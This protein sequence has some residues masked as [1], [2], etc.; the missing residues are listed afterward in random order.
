MP[1]TI[2]SLWQSWSLPVPATLALVLAAWYYLRGW[3]HLRK[4]LPTAIPPWRAAA[5][6]FGTLLVWI[7]IGSPLAALDE[8]LLSVHMLQHLLLMTAGPPLILLGSPVLPLLHGLPKLFI[9]GVWGPFFRL[10][11]VRRLERIL[12]NP[13]L[14]WL[15]APVALL[16]WHVPA[17]YELGLRSEWWHAIEHGSFLT[18]GLLFWWPVIP[19]WPGVSRPRW[20]L[21]LYLFLA[22]L[23]C[24][25]L[26][27]FLAFCD[28]VVYPSYLVTPRRV[29]ITALQDQQCAGAL[30]WVCVTFACL[31]PAVAITTRL[32]S[33]PGT[34]ERK[35]VR[36]PSC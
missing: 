13:V 30:M 4:I 16:G 24:D 2:Q 32:L 3:L 1:D 33:T 20:S 27:A 17:A 12:T 28:R 7:A 25:A 18:A 5:F 14:C 8:A 34:Y 22:T 35:F 21:V 6:L 9:R 31:V 36:A 29:G 19:S 15:A 26:S 10:P 11:P 23:P